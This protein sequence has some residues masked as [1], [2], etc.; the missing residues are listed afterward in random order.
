MNTR[1]QVLSAIAIASL[2]T[3]C[4]AAIV[5]FEGPQPDNGTGFGNILNVLSLQHRPEEAGSVIRQ[6]GAD[7]LTGDATNTS[8]TRTVAEF[9]ASGYDPSNLGVIFNI[10]DPGSSPNVTLNQFEV[11][12]YDASD[13][14]LFTAL[15]SGP[16]LNL[17]PVSM[18]TGGAGYLFNIELTP[19]ELAFFNDPANRIG[20][21]VTTP[22]QSTAAGAENFFVIPSPG[23]TALLALAGTLIFA[24]RRRIGN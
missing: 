7:V 2:P 8:Q 16:S 5:T 4:S 22:I 3:L 13:T 1:T 9:L 11:L 18:G 24:P 21:R 20:L 19:A 17:A 15:Y 23:T 14:L 10:N 12:F 6:N